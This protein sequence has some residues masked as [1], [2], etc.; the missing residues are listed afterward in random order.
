MNKPTQTNEL[1][2]SWKPCSHPISLA[3]TRTPV[4]W[5]KSKSKVPY[6]LELK[7]SSRLIDDKSRCNRLFSWNIR[8][9]DDVTCFLSILSWVGR[10][11]DYEENLGNVSRLWVTPCVHSFA[12]DNHI[13]EDMSVNLNHHKYYK[14]SRYPVFKRRLSPFSNWSSTSPSRMTP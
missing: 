14:G 3:V 4:D 6:K 12:L 8:L 5:L 7:S 9:V 13:S 10:R 1:Q 11:Y 2:A